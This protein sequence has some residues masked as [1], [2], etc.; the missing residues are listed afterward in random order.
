M[1]RLMIFTVPI[2]PVFMTMLCL[3]SKMI[4][5]MVMGNHMGMCHAIMRMDNGMRVTMPVIFYHSIVHDKDCS[6]QRKF[7]ISLDKSG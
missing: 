6:G 5:F 4:M 3:I 1:C 7:I 2:I